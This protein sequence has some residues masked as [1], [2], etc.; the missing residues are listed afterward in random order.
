[1]KQCVIMDFGWEAK[2][3]TNSSGSSIS[4]ESLA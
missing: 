2:K 1:M 4:A 3:E